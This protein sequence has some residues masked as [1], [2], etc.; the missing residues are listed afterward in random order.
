MDA[1]SSYQ[2]CDLL[3]IETVQT[4]HEESLI[5]RSNVDPKAS[6]KQITVDNPKC[7]NIISVPLRQPAAENPDVP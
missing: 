2:N 7:F 4:L 6:A 5:I 3:V 1:K